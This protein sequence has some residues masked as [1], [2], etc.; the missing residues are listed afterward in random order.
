[1]QP[2]I[3]I[4]IILFIVVTLAIST[5]K[6]VPQTEEYVIEFLGRYQTTWKAGIHFLIPVV[7]RIV[8]KASFKEQ[9]ADFEPQSVITKDNVTSS[10]TFQ[11]RNGNSCSFCFDLPSAVDEPSQNTFYDN[12]WRS[13]TQ[14]R[15]DVVKVQ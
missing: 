2:F 7:Q 6:V 9:C 1:M 10:M 8:S 14:L 15:Y 4:V 13:S 3:V 12:M 11:N 5:I